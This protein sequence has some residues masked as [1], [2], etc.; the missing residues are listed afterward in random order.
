MTIVRMK[1]GIKFKESVVPCRNMCFVDD[2][3]RHRYFELQFQIEDVEVF[4]R[5][6]LYWQQKPITTATT[7][8]PSLAPISQTSISSPQKKKLTLSAFP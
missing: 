2:L 8:S 4:N 6:C 5:I 1:V 3:D 7:S